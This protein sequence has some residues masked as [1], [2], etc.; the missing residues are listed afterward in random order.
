[1]TTTVHSTKI[2]EVK[3]KI[4][5]HARYITT[6]EFDKLT[7]E[8]FTTRLQPGNLVNKTDF[9]NKLINFNINIYKIFSS[10]KKAK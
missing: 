5:D 2:S 3:N 8:K 7:T 9:D 10:S 4:P 6:S 1:M